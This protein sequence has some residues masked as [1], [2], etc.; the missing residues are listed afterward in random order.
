MISICYV[1]KKRD[2]VTK[3]VWQGSM[4]KKEFLKR[5]MRPF[6]WGLGI[7]IIG[8]LI[9][10]LC[11]WMDILHI[12]LFFGGMCFGLGLICWIGSCNDKKMYNIVKSDTNIK[13]LEITRDG[14][15]IYYT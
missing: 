12:L 4:E 5:I 11:V 3:Y 6:R 13:Y 7:M 9:I 8:I 2:L 15:Y 1:V 14:E 10:V